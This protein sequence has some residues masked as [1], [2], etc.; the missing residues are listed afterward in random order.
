MAAAVGTAVMAAWWLRGCWC[1]SLLVA[2]R[3]GRSWLVRSCPGP[4]SYT[5]AWSSRWCRLCTGAACQSWRLMEEFPLLRCLPRRGVRSL[6][7]GHFYFCLRI[8]QSLFWCMGVACGVQRIGCFGTRALLGSTV[9]TCSSK[10]L[11]E[12]TYFLRCSELES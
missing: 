3:Q 7:S 1:G 9:D 8:F 11:E 2:E 5:V 6:K 10:A 4:P 12:F